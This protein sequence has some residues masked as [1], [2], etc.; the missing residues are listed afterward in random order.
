MLR[1]ARKQHKQWERR[2]AQFGLANYQLKNAAIQQLGTNTGAAFPPHDAELR[3]AW[4]GQP[5]LRRRY[6]YA[7]LYAMHRIPAHRNLRQVPEWALNDSQCRVLLLHLYPR[8]LVK[9]NPKAVRDIRAGQGLRKMAAVT[10]LVLYRAY[11]QLL[12][13]KVIAEELGVSRHAVSNRLDRL[14]RTAKE[15]FGKQRGRP[16]LR[17]V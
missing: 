6:A 8:L 14:N 10:A 17:K 12:S 1:C 3:G 16:C 2:L 4:W 7:D 5:G 15:L 13:D 9:R 11:R